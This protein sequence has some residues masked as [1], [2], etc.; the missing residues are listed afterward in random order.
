MKLLSVLILF[1]FCEFELFAQQ[2]ILLVGTSH[3]T[4]DN[5]L[6][7]MLPVS[8]AI[9]KFKPDVICTEYRKPADSASL[10]YLYGN[11]HFAI[12][13]SVIKA[14]NLSTSGMYTKI[15]IIAKQL[16]KKNDL[17]LRMELRNL[18]YVNS[19]FGN[20]D[21]QAYLIIN[22]LKK[23]SSQIKILRAKFPMYDR[24]KARY[25]KRIKNNDEYN[26][27]VFPL[28]DRLSI[29]YLD[30]IDDQS[31]N[32]KYEKYFGVLQEMDSTIE[33]R[34]NYNQTIQAFFKKINSLPKDSNMWVYQNS[35]EIINDLMYVE[36]YKV[37]ASNES[38]EVKMVSYYYGLRNKKMASYIDEVAKKNPKKKLVVFF[39]CS[40]VGPIQEEL[41]KLNRNY[42]ILTLNDLGKK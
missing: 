33:D 21:Y 8:E 18:Y 32:D 5:N 6:W 39:G 42:S 35:P 34:K 2:K 38:E 31:T 7:Q 26:R 30:P 9:L 10:K 36:A 12:Q 17:I 29:S 23:D 28:A 1:T 24:M 19:D 37:N 40:H 4:T 15:K 11:T 3:Q 20:S 14:W 25:D 22:Y 16:D 27:L 41:K 13:D